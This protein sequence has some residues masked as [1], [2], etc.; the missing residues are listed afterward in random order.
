LLPGVAHKEHTKVVS[1]LACREESWGAVGGRFSP[2]IWLCGDVG[3]VMFKKLF[4]MDI[5]KGNQ[6]KRF[7]TGICSQSIQQVETQ[8]KDL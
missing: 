6:E 4:Q 2:L 3:H 1:S 8:T 5:S 7:E